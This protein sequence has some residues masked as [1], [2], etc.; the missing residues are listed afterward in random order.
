MTPKLCARLLFFALMASLGPSSA[1][2]KDYMLRF[3]TPDRKEQALIRTI[4]IETGYWKLYHQEP[5]DRGFSIRKNMEIAF[6]R[7]GPEKEPEVLTITQTP[8]FCGSAGCTLDIWQHQN[9]RWVQIDGDNIGGLGSV[10][11]ILGR[12]THGFHALRVPPDPADTEFDGS[13][14]ECPKCPEQG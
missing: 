13:M 12:K 14:Y 6:Y 9:G 8:G 3:H 2:A 11:H 1:N 5:Q 7:L 4:L 10:L